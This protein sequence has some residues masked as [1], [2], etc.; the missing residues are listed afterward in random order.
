MSSGATRSIPTPH[1]A[2][3]SADQ[4]W[5]DLVAGKAFPL[6]LAG[7]FAA[8]AEARPEA[9]VSIVARHEKRGAPHTY[10]SLSFRDCR[11]WADQFARGIAARGIQPGD[12]VL[13]LMKPMLD[14]VPIFLALWKAGAVPVA[15]DP[16]APRSQKLKSIREIA[17]TALIGIPAAHALRYL[18][19]KPFRSIARGLT[20][21][22]HGFPG[23][24][25]LRSFLRR[26]EAG[27]VSAPTTTGDTMAIVFTTGSTGPPKGVVYTQGNG[28]AIIRIMKDALGIR[29]DD[30][31]LACHP[32]F[33]LY[34]VGAGATVVTPDMDPR[35]PQAADPACLLAIIRDWKPTVSFMQIPVIRNLWTYCA[36]RGEK[37]PHLGK[38]LTTGATVPADLIEGVHQV[39]AE[40]GADLHVMYG[41][42]E[43]LCVSY[44]TGREILA[45]TP[46]AGEA[47]GTY[48]GRPSPGVTAGIIGIDDQPIPQWSRDLLLPEGQIG[49]ICVSGPVVTPRYEGLPEATRKAKMPSAT[50]LWHRMGDAGYI[51]RDGALWYCGRI[52]DRVET[53]DGYLYSDLVE[54][55]FNSHPAVRRSA[56]VGVP[57]AGFSKKRPVIVVEPKAAEDAAS[58]ARERKLAGE[59]RLLAS[60]HIHASRIEDVLI[61][62]EAFPVDVRHG[63]KIRRDLLTRYAAERI[64]MQQEKLPAQNSVLFDGHRVAY[65]Q[66]GQ[67]DP[68]LFLHNAGNDHYV[69][70]HQLVYFSRSYRVIGVDS[71]GYGR[72]DSPKIEYSLPLY[73]GMVAAL[74]D[75]LSLAPVTIVATCTGAAMALNY[76]F[77]NPRQV[78]RLVLFHIA[79][80]KTVLGGSL[81]RTTRM[82][83]G[84]PLA[85]RVVG[86]ATEAM[87]HRGLL[88]RA[89]IQAQYGGT[90]TEDPAFTAHLHQLYSRNG[91]GTCLINLFSNWHSFA[92]LDRAR[93]PAEF[94]PLHV[95]WGDANKV[96]PLAR[97]KELC[98]TLNPRTFDSI[99]GGGHLVMR[100]K[101]ELINRRIEELLQLSGQ[102]TA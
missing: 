31:C 6:N 58:P 40:P 86:A 32:A 33:A 69:W 36:A 76:A 20:V 42:T 89:I 25:T 51:D 67:G 12:T 14:F 90:S 23:A 78:R 19:R 88:H 43:A 63:A 83:S 57:I 68:I 84:R 74:V 15:L 24:P 29:S 54:P 38:I 65:Y 91:E 35:Y 85:A 70:E 11:A 97:G 16:G 9:P 21:G 64:G 30:I 95:L 73:T 34:F 3:G 46:R 1:L 8:L 4:R 87:M 72:S 102:S 92:P 77:E 100:E 2:Q 94:P 39:L 62:G 93:C 60:H 52:A 50:G 101:P 53:G 13:I 75:S 37:I 79:T 99:E 22:T 10:Q 56:L 71:L 7:E 48:L 66:D 17:P 61:S 28:A 80:E 5:Q 41:A 82:V 18:Y 27:Q 81:E 45:A 44:A 96:I 55:V 26:P 98:A 49:E 59:L 47:K